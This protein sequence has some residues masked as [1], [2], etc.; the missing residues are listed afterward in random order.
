MASTRTHRTDRV[1]RALEELGACVD[2]LRA[3][4][5]SAAW[6]FAFR[7]RLVAPSRW[8]L[9]RAAAAIGLRPEWV[10]HG[11]EIPHYLLTDGK[12][13]QAMA[14]GARVIDDDGVRAMAGVFRRDGGGGGAGAGGGGG[15]DDGGVLFKRE[16]SAQ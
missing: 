16:G 15:G 6:P 12:R 4:A 14:R 3:C 10:R 2:G 9:D 8:A 7:C 5:P 11:P 13:A 1:D